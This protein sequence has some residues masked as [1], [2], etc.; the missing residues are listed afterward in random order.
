M[1][2]KKASILYDDHAAIYGHVLN[3]IFS[4]TDFLHRP[5]NSTHLAQ[6]VITLQIVFSNVPK[7]HSP[8]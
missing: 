7:Q 1:S 6:K 2:V 4:F 8:V 5:T 3:L